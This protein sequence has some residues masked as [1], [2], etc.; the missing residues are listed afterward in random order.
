MEHVPPQLQPLGEGAGPQRH[1]ARVR[2]HVREGGDGEDARV[3]SD[4]GDGRCHELRQL[5][6]QHGQPGGAS[7]WHD[8]AIN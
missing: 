5:Y 2:V 3:G 6:G 8:S 7:H 4:G 1:G